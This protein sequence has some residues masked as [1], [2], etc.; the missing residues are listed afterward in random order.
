M[1]VEQDSRGA[2]DEN[3]IKRIVKAEIAEYGPEIERM[4][5]SAV[6]KSMAAARHGGEARQARVREAISEAFGGMENVVSAAYIPRE[7]NYWPLLIVHDSDSPADIIK[8]ITRKIMQVEEIP[9]V[10]LLH[11]QLIHVS[12]TTRMP[13]EARV[14]FARAMS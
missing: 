6:E 1:A 12:E 14:V 7:E 10:P 8:R 9:S 3:A 11:P 5:G 4:I 2:L 13:P